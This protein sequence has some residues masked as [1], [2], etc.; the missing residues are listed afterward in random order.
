MIHENS[1]ICG[2][3]LDKRSQ[4]AIEYMLML[5]AVLAVVASIIYLVLLTFRGL[6]SAVE[7][8]IENVR[9]DVI[10]GLTALLKP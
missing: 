2:G 5:G 7:D 1:V 9:K 8:T 3:E 10:D 6:G 4:G